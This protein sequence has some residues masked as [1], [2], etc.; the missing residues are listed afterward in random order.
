MSALEQEIID[1]FH[2]LEPAAKQRVLETLA[3]DVQASFDYNGWW[4]QVEAL[5]ASIKARLGDQATVGTLSL[6]AELR[7]EE[8]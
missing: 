4:K 3:F 5:Q 8:S 1:K 6:L 7:E 2:L